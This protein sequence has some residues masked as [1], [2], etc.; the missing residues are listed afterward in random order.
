MVKAFDDAV[1]LR[2]IVDVQVTNGPNFLEV[3]CKF[4]IQE[5]TPT[6]TTQAGYA[7]RIAVD[8]DPGFVQFIGLEGL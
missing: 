8:L 1:G 4:I 7:T 6:I 3:R 5:L 2:G